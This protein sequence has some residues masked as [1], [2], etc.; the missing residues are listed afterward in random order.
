VLG[1]PGNLN[2]E[3]SRQAPDR[4]RQKR[5]KQNEQTKTQEIGDKISTW[6][7]DQPDGL[8]TVLAVE[9]YRGRRKRGRP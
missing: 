6:F 5:T 9:P 8:S 2:Y 1:K 3:R 7:S 4:L